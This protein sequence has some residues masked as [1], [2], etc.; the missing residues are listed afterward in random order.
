MTMH[1]M[2]ERAGVKRSGPGAAR[3]QAVSL[4][5]DEPVLVD[6]L[7][8]GGFPTV[9]LPGLDGVDPIA[10]AAGHRDLVERLLSARGALLFRGF[11]LGVDAFERFVAAACGEPLPYTERSSPRSRVSGNIYTSTDH[12]ADAEIFLHNEQSYNLTFPLRIAFLCALPAASGGA[13]PLADVR[14]VYRRLSPKVRRPFVEKG[15]MIVRNFGQGLGLPWQDA[16]QTTDRERVGEYCRDHRIDL[17]WK[18]DGGLRTRQVRP[19]VARHPRTG[20]P[21]WC[22][23]ATFFHV[24]TLPA[25]L[26]DSLLSQLAVEDLPNNTYYGDGAAIEAEVLDQLRLAYRRETVAV[27]WQRGD[28]LLLDNMLCAHGREPFTG[29][30]QVVVG[31]AAPTSWSDLE[32]VD[33]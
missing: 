6:E 10:W 3:R 5:G 7:A 9:L 25:P 32:L 19:A 11:D 13:T 12:R 4:S 24:S 14:R 31:M 23:H 16:F 22:N 21:C 2:H 15:Y 28:V 18:P 8:H 20:E 1:D 27:S 30:R 17:T 33:A 26:R 29:P